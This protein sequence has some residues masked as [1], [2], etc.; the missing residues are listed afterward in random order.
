MGE[1]VFP[2]GLTLAGVLILVE[3]GEGIRIGRTVARGIDG[4]EGDRA[5]DGPEV[6]GGRGSADAKRRVN[7]HRGSSVEGPAERIEARGGLG[8]VIAAFGKRA[9]AVRDLVALEVVKGG[10]PAALAPGEFAAGSEGHLEVAPVAM[11]GDADARAQFRAAEIAPR[12]VV[13]HAG[14]G[15]RTVDG[16]GAVAQDVDALNALGGELVDVGIEGRDAAVVGGDRV[17]R[18]APAVEEHEG[19]AGPDTAEVDVRIVA[20]GVGAAVLGFVEREIGH[21]RQRGEHLD[22][23]EGIAGLDMVEAEDG[24]GQDLFLVESLD[25]RAGDGEG[26]EFNDVDVGVFLLG[27]SGGRGWSGLGDQ[28]RGGCE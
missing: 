17:R 13:D 12:D 8:G 20:A 15:V 18:E 16:R 28:R 23:G 1:P 4:G 27:R 19:V 25:V 22:R 5:V 26:L 9:A 10:E 24:D 11:L 6:I 7:A 3:V 2:V 21:L 14:D